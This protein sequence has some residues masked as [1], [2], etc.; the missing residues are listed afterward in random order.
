MNVSNDTQT[1]DLLIESI[2]TAA[3]NMSPVRGAA[4]API[5]ENAIGGSYGV[6]MLGIDM[7]PV[8]SIRIHQEPLA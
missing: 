2:E 7:M 1:G 3:S 6:V 5:A 8:S 4:V